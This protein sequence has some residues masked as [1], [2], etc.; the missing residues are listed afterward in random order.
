LVKLCHIIRSGPVFFLRLRVQASVFHIG[1][2]K[3]L[4]TTQPSH[5]Y[6]LISVQPPSNTHSSSVVTTHHY[7]TIAIFLFKNYWSFISFCITISLES[8]SCFISS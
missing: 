1:L 7:S 6:K 3:V 2:Y 4:T 5:L 8:A